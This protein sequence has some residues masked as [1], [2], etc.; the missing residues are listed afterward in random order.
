MTSARPH[1]DYL[2]KS[3]FALVVWIAIFATLAL[4]TTLALNFLFS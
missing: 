4:I 3:L 2:T 1:W